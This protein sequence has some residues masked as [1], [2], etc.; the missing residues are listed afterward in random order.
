MPLSQRKQLKIKFK[1]GRIIR[2]EPSICEQ[3]LT[4]SQRRLQHRRA[5]S[6][7][8]GASDP[9]MVSAAALTAI[10]SS[11]VCIQR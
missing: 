10:H 9:D 11:V 1:A 2:T 4:E 6:S 8:A 7:A 3:F 5:S